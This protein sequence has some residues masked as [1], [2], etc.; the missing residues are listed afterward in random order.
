MSNRIHNYEVFSSQNAIP[1]L[2]PHL[3]TSK[4]SQSDF[5][6][7]LRS[8]VPTYSTPHPPRENRYY[9]E[10]ILDFTD[11][12]LQIGIANGEKNI[13]TFFYSLSK[14]M[15][16][17]IEHLQ[18]ILDEIPV[19]I[20]FTQPDQMQLNIKLLNKIINELNDIK[21]RIIQRWN[22]CVVSIDVEKYKRQ[23]QRLTLKGIEL[24]DPKY[25]YKDF[26]TIVNFY[27]TILNTDYD[28]T[29]IYREYANFLTEWL[30][31][32]PE[33]QYISVLHAKYLKYIKEHYQYQVDFNYYQNL[34]D[35]DYLKRGGGRNKINCIN[36]KMKYVRDLCKANEI[37]LSTTKNDKRVI[38]TKKELITKLKRKKII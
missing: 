8:P 3:R 33:K 28:N 20:T 25:F 36:M 34:Y 4:H 10:R 9:P 15:T 21:V 6:F 17:N 35:P 30:D 5:S 24:L 11:R 22:I 14:M 31:H 23:D 32:E 38:Y 2:S 19:P 37:K 16:Q 18:T 13:K 27:M 7:P 29:E 1:R 12:Q 26:V